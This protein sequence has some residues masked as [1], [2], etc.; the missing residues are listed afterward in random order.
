MCLTGT[1]VCILRKETREQNKGFVL[2]KG[3]SYGDDGNLEHKP[4]WEIVDDAYYNKTTH[5]RQKV[6]LENQTEG[7]MN[8]QHWYSM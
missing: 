3:K 4:F 1:I 7:M 5:H 2:S 6:D 8:K